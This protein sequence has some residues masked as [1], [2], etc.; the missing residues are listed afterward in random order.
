MNYVKIIKEYLIMSYQETHYSIEGRKQPFPFPS[1]TVEYNPQSRLT[2]C[3]VD[4][5]PALLKT[6][7][8]Y[9][10]SF[11]RSLYAIGGEVFRRK[12]LV[13][14]EKLG[15]SGIQDLQDSKPGD[16]QQRTEELTRKSL[17]AGLLQEIYSP[18]RIS[19]FDNG[20]L[21]LA[22]GVTQGP[23]QQYSP[24]YLVVL[25]YAKVTLS[26]LIK[27]RQLL[28][29]LPDGVKSI[30]GSNAYKDLDRDELVDEI[31]PNP[32]ILDVLSQTF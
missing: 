19:R 22:Q 2:I 25:S 28:A 16:W 12:G 17:E 15:L 20:Y 8:D 29:N 11:I 13:S 6:T 27:A 24:D 10:L 1:V 26:D 5:T 3:R 14:L 9:S 21:F 4:R 30:L 7:G 23:Y 18:A 31:L 32:I